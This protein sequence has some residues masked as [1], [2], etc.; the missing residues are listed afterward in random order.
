MRKYSANARVARSPGL[1]LDRWRSRRRQRGAVAGTGRRHRAREAPAVLPVAGGRGPKAPALAGLRRRACTAA[2][3]PPIAT[4]LSC[5]TPACAAAVVVPAP[6]WCTTAATRLKS[7]CRFTSPMERQS[8]SLSGSVTPAHPRD[9][10]ARR[11]TARA[12]LMIVWLTSCGAH[13]LNGA[14][15]VV[16][17]QS[18]RAATLPQVR[19]R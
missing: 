2:A 9:T 8:G 7:A 5:D 19:N 14:H 15:P 11:P 17:Q 18:T 3:C 1:R 6:P 12:A 13:V 10:I 16:A 4:G